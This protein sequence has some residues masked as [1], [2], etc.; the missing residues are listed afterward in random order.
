MITQESQYQ[1][2]QQM[3]GCCAKYLETS[4]SLINTC[5]TMF[6]HSADWSIK[7]GRVIYLSESQIKTSRYGKRPYGVGLLIAGYDDQGTHIY[8]T[9]PSAEYFEYYAFAIGSRSQSAKT[10]LEKCCDSLKNLNADELIMHGLKA[11]KSS[12]PDTVLNEKNVTLAV[13]GKDMPF[14]QFEEKEISQFLS[15]ISQP[16]V[17]GE[18]VKMSA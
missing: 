15:K 13:V 4:A 3:E 17:A 8:Q 9:C 1:E 18:E 14:K 10:Y 5:L 11:L 6:T 2:S 7:L 12:E 16:V